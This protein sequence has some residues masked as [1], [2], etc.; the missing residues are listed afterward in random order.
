MPAM[1][2]V[3]HIDG[4]LCLYYGK[5][6]NKIEK[7]VVVP[8]KRVSDEQAFYSGLLDFSRRRGFKDGWAKVKYKEKYGAWPNGLDDKQM[9]PRKAVREFI[10]ESMR[11]YREEKKKLEQPAP[12]PYH[13]EF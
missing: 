5:A 12:E 7:P 4:E 11:K 9:T 2:D 8:K 13:A 10:R 3:E 1:S 6:K